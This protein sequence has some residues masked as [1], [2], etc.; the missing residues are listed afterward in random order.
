MRNS[1]NKIQFRFDDC[2]TR[3]EYEYDGVYKHA[4]IKIHLKNILCMYVVKFW[5]LKIKQF[6]HFYE[7]KKK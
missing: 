5:T 6:R 4:C 7:D 2:S 3:N 1:Q